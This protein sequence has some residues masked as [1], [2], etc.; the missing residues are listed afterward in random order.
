MRY[1]VLIWLAV[2][3]FYNLAEQAAMQHNTWEMLW[4]ALAC[5]G[6]H[7]RREQTA[8]VHMAELENVCVDWEHTK[9]DAHLALHGYE[10]HLDFLW[11]HPTMK[12]TTKNKKWILRPTLLIT[13]PWTNPNHQ[14]WDAAAMLFDQPRPVPYTQW[15]APLH[16]CSFWLCSFMPFLLAALNMTVPLVDEPITDTHAI[17]FRRAWVPQFARNRA[18]NNLHESREYAVAL[19]AIRANMTAGLSSPAGTVLVYGK[20]DSKLRNWK[21]AAAEASRLRS[22]G[23]N[24]DYIANM[25]ALPFTEQCFKF[26]SAQHI[27]YV[28]GGQTANLICARP[29]TRIV[30]FACPVWVGW[31][32]RA[33]T[34]QRIMGLEYHYRKV[35]GCTGH[36]TSF[37][38]PVGWIDNFLR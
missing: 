29:G 20:A 38:T 16:Q 8:P 15:M 37:D 32:Q 4:M 5:V 24:V 33:R 27:V 30:E 35:P 25:S 12:P 11:I 18:E 36:Y 14:F 21:N 10:Q 34:F 26:W 6:V 22:M 2:A 23:F 19:P 9:H 17:C 3:E 28:H 31:F 13:A 7:G 1:G